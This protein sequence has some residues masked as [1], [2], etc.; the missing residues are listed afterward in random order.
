MKPAE[1][2][3]EYT[4]LRAEGRSYS[5]ITQ[6]LHINKSTYTKLEQ[7][8]RA[9]IAQLKKE[10]L[11]TLYEAYAMKKEGRTKLL[12]ETLAWI[13]ALDL[14]A[15]GFN[16]EEIKAGKP[17][18]EFFKGV[19]E[20]FEEFVK[21]LHREKLEAFEELVKDLDREKKEMDES[22][23]LRRALCY[24]VE[25]SSKYY[26]V[27]HGKAIDAILRMIGS[28][29]T[30]NPLNNTGSIERGEV[31]LIIKSLDT[32]TST[33]RA[34]THKLLITAIARFTANN[35]TGRGKDRT[36]ATAKVSIPLKDYA[37]KCG[38][39]VEE[40]PTDNPEEAEKEALR[41]KRTLDNARRKVQEDLALLYNASIS[42][43]EKVKGKDADFA[44]V[45]IL[46]G[47][48]I[49]AGRINIEF[50]VSLAEYLILLPLT[51]FP[52]ALLSLDERNSN[53]YTIGWKMALHYSHDNNQ[54]RGTAQLLKVKTMLE[55]TNL[56]TISEVRTQEGSWRYRIK[57]P[58]EA[59]L[60]A[61]TACGL[62]EDW[63]YSHSKGEEM[64]DEEATSFKNYEEWADTLIHF[65]LKNAPRSAPR[66]RTREAEKK[67]LRAKTTG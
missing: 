29:P 25:Q 11:N 39:D 31:K 30:R 40:H 5:Y 60:D 20:A 51:Q 7:E 41:V 14:M 43:K 62:L 66:L 15:K 33:L 67:A 26:P 55:R 54:I 46:G 47:K 63:R 61:L 28:K 58:F 34:S 56:P 49:K 12:G 37:L 59:A 2:K 18:V 17:P 42:W 52:P 23:D 10:E 64:T 45:R 27:L 24:S 9:T 4:R 36:L 8:L 19:L 6:E 48:G 16:I 65:I 21:G 53:A 38:Y 50:S 3:Q 1:L 35:H 13:T 22:K 44:D 32:L 57:E